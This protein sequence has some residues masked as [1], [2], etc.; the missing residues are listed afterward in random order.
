MPD[1]G[2][3]PGKELDYLREMINIGSGHAASALSQML[4]CHIELKMP[5]LYM[6]PA[7]KV[8][9]VLD[10]GDFPVVCVKMDLVGDIR[11]EVF[12]IVPEREKTRITSMAEKANLGTSRK[13]APD[14]SVLEET[15][16][17]MAGAY[18]TA[19]HDFCKLNIYHSVP[20]AVTDTFQATIDELVADMGRH[21]DAIFVVES[22][23]AIV[24]ESAV[25]SDERDVRT[26]FIVFPSPESVKT[27]VDSIK[28]AMSA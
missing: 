24:V 9:A 4:Q 17:I 12:F 19:I 15:G 8:P 22:E 23:F 21:S 13:G 25:T 20:V 27:L 3:L 14:I 5:R 26:F 6:V 2:N 16:N 10:V 11:G 28:N 18:L 1:A 7:K